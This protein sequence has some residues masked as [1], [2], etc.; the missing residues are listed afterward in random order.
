LVPFEPV[1]FAPRLYLNFMGMAAINARGYDYGMCMG[2]RILPK[3]SSME[4]GLKLVI[5]K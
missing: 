1:K 4:M 2:A 5:L 3:F